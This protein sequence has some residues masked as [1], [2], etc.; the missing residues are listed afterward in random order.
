MPEIVIKTEQ[1][2]KKFS[3]IQQLLGCDDPLPIDNISNHLQYRQYYS[4]TT[5]RI[6]E[7]EY[8]EDLTAFEYEF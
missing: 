8:Q 1:L 7:E 6:I 2:D 5:Q 4:P 3:I